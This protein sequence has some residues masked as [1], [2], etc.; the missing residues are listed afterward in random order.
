MS[1]IYNGDKFTSEN[2]PE[3]AEGFVYV[4]TVEVDNTL[5]KYI[6]KKNF[7]SIR[8]K[9]L[10]KKRQPLDKRLKSYE[11]I[12][13][14]DYENYYSSNEVLKNA[15]KEGLLINREIL[16]I[17]FS[18]TELTYQEVKHQFLH[19]VLEKNEYLN[20]NIL[21]KFYKQINYEYNTKTNIDTRCSKKNT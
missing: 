20:A 13:K 12:K 5:Y 7:Y 10:S 1:W 16:K 3:Q 9:K 18:K 14:L 4:M 6:G 21:G 11:I 2:I 15:H 19:E 8:K 17:C